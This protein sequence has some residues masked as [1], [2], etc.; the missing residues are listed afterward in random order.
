MARST[1]LVILINNIHIYFIGSETLPSTCHILSD[2][3]PFCAVGF[4]YFYD[5]IDKM[6]KNAIPEYPN[7]STGI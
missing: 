6:G 1:R 3:I 5:R 4:G 2:D 7:F